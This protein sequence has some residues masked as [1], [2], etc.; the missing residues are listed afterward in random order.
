MVE[1]IGRR[2]RKERKAL[3]LSLKEL[4]A[5]VGISTM[6]LQRIETEKTSPSVSVLAQIASHLRQTIDYFIHEKR[7]KMVVA[8]KENQPTIQSAG[9][10]LRVIV[11]L[12]MTDKS[13]LVNFGE[14]DEGSFINPHVEEGH[15][16]VYVL[17]GA[18]VLEH[19]GVEHFLNEGD[20]VF[21]DARYSHQVKALDKK[22]RFLSVFFK[23]KG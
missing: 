21:Y 5:K 6:T 1:T 17:E 11:P 20:A 4:A 12:E 18:A 2:I 19:D 16:L 15:S 3:N 8:K 22:H 9:M 23:E 10:T 13:I 14:A 7:P